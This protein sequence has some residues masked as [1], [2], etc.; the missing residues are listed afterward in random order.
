MSQNPYESPASELGRPP[1]KVSP[2]RQYFINAGL[3]AGI[4]LGPM[5]M[6]ALLQHD[7]DSSGTAAGGIATLAVSVAVGGVAGA[8]FGWL[9]ACVVSRINRS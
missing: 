6:D 4:V 7:S 2:Y 1:R 8:V 3:G 9:V 5:V